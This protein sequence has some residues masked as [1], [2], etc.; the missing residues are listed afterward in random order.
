MS[1]TSTIRNFLPERGIHSLA[2]AVDPNVGV[3]VQLP[4]SYHV[5]QNAV[6][7]DDNGK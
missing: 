3:G 5:H 6:Q 2:E 7:V 1:I 4:D